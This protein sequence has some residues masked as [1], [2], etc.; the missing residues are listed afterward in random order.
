MPNF[1]EQYCS[2]VSN[3]NVPLTIDKLYSTDKNFSDELTH[4]ELHEVDLFLG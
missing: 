4:A 1:V 2:F 3:K